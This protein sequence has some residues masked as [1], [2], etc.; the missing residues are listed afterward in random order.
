MHVCFMNDAEKLVNPITIVRM[1]KWKLW[2][3]YI[4][5]LNSVCGLKIK[6]FINLR[7][8]LV[9]KIRACTA[10][11]SVKIIVWLLRLS[12]ILDN[13][14]GCVSYPLD[15]SYRRKGEQSWIYSIRNAH[16]VISKLCS[17]VYQSVRIFSMIM[18]LDTS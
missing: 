6:D 4:L 18:R 12:I 2:Q 16:V 10:L 17:M 3:D 1:P 15:D 8:F 7:L 9:L 11:K 14:I 5:I 13:S